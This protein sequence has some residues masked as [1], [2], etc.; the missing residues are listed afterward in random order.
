[1]QTMNQKQANQLEKAGRVSL[2]IAAGFF[3]TYQIIDGLFDFAL[4]PLLLIALCFFALGMKFIITRVNHQE[5][6]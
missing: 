1:M 2:G 6:R 5:D 3:V 4:Y